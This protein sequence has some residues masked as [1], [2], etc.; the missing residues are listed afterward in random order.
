MKVFIG[1]DD[2]DAINATYGTGKVVRS[3]WLPKSAMPGF[4]PPRTGC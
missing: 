4:P 1:F 3:K 2:T